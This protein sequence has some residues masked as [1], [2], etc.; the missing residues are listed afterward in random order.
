M[1]KAA[2]DVDR[3]L[4]PLHLELMLL[5]HSPT[6]GVQA[7]KIRLRGYSTDEI[8]RCFL[9]LRASGIIRVMACTDIAGTRYC[10]HLVGLTPLGAGLLRCEFMQRQLDRR[11]LMQLYGDSV[12]GDD[13]MSK[14]ISVD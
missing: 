9:R 14:A 5:F 8:R 11:K 7:G 2:L 1:S 13:I 3:T 10:G 6:P 12:L 4:R